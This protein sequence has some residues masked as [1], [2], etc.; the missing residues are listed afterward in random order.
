VERKGSG[1]ECGVFSVEFLSARRG[2]PLQLGEGRRHLLHLSIIVKADAR[3][4][5]G[6]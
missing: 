3:K 2:R 5:P 6:Q 4:Q 1:R